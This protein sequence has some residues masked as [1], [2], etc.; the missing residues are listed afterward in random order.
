MFPRKHSLLPL[1]VGFTMCGRYVFFSHCVVLWIALKFPSM[2]NAYFTLHLQCLCL[3][4]NHAFLL[5]LIQ[6][7]IRHQ[8]DSAVFQSQYIVA[9]YTFQGVVTGFVLVVFFLAECF[10]HSGCFTPTRF[11]K[12]VPMVTLLNTFPCAL[13]CPLSS[14]PSEEKV[15]S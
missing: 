4:L 9:D 8:T 1:P 13:H 3:E 11:C 14:L 2:M 12:M 15:V 5:I 6:P 7:C 10:H